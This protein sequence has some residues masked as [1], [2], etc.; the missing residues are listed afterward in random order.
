MRATIILAALLGMALGGCGGDEKKESGTADEFLKKEKAKQAEKEKAEAAKK[1]K[2]AEAKPKADE[3]KEPTPAPPPT[4][5]PTEPA[6]PDKAAPIPT[7]EVQNALALVRRGQYEQA[8]NQA[9]AAL[10]RN[11]K[12]AP[13]MV[14]MA[15]AYFQLGK[16]EFAESVCDLALS[17]DATQGDCHIIKGFVAL[18]NDNDPVAREQF[19]KATK[20][21]PGLG[22]GWLNLGVQYLKVKNYTAAITALE[23]AVRLLPSRPDA[24]LNLGSAYRGAGAQDQLTKAQA[25][26]TKA[27]Q[28]KPNYP[29]AYFNLGVL[30]LDA[31][32]FPGMTKLQQLNTAVTHFN[33]YKRAQP[34]L[35]ADDPVDGYIKQAQKDYERETK[36]LQ[37]EAQR[38]AREAAKKAAPAPAPAP[39][40]APPAPKK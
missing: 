40:A 28:L 35:P 34:R 26:Y 11:E 2:V 12:Y 4:P 39:K 20:A 9:K 3:K 10:R 17:I 14:V 18:K 21:K 25:S 27:L 19:E 5:A 15:R 16:S 37:R 23:E 36:A 1:E 13:A 30:F 22:A 6:V 33:S 8:I 38:K 7:A 24:H 29:A 31:A 32:T